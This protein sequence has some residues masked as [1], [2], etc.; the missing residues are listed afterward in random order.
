LL[1]VLDVP[2]VR[3]V[4]TKF[5]QT[6]FIIDNSNNLNS[7]LLFGGNRSGFLKRAVVAGFFENLYKPFTS[8]NINQKS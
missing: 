3:N 8:I 7:V 6:P 4:E 5:S 2:S 1:G